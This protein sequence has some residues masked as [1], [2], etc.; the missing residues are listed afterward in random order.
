VSEDK[1]R[2]QR[3]ESE[4]DVEAHRHHVMANEVPKAE[5]E[6]SD[7]DDFEAHILSRL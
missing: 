6:D 3:E 5:G 4:E 2:P 1:D 7:D